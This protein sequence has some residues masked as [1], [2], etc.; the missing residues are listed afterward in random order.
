MSATDEK[1]LQLA[2]LLRTV[3]VASDNSA[4]VEAMKNAASRYGLRSA[5]YLGSGINPRCEQL[6]YLAV[7]YSTEWVEHYK[8]QDYI[9]IDPAV[10][11]GLRRLLPLDWKEF[12]KHQGRL[13]SFFGEASEFG[14]GRSGLTIPVH[15]RGSDR[16]ILTITSDLSDVAWGR[17]KLEYIRDFNLLALQLHNKVLELE[18]RQGSPAK[19][20]PRELECLQWIAEGKTA[21]ECAMILGLSQHTVRCYLES[22]RHKL[23]AASNTHAVSIAHRAGLF[24]PLV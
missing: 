14:L 4:L 12:G 6:P 7:T 15:G 1:D 8:N 3:Q 24:N 10:Q 21:W 9:E 2:E 18:G 19:L 17:E 11:I 13:K 23:N 16:A 5:A 22:A 20:S